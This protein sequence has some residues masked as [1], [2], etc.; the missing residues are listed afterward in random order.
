M[1]LESHVDGE[2][3]C[4][5][6][7]HAWMPSQPREAELV[8]R[9]PVLQR[10]LLTTDGTVTT[11][12]GTMVGEP[13]CVSML[14]QERRMLEAD[15]AELQLREG[16]E[17]L[18]RRVLLRGSYSSRPLLL[19]YSR[20]ALSR[21]PRAPRELLLSGDVA[22]GLV[23]RSHRIETFRAPLRIG[24]RQAS[25]YVAGLLGAGLMCRRTYTIDSG[26]IAVM[27]VHEQF[28][29]SGFTT[30]DR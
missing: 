6:W 9:L 26:G 25:S 18:I 11:A 7:R 20:I 16:G 1:N 22:I 24:V 3:E 17:V 8:A 30:A 15:D 19:G 5:E 12:L 29:A 27:V 21:L 28:P 4:V 14:G 23:L 2:V 10:M 13:V